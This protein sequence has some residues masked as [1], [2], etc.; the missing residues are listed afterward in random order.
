MCWCRPHC[1]SAQRE[2]TLLEYA[3][4]ICQQDKVVAAAGRG[5]VHV[6]SR[7]DREDGVDALVHGPAQRSAA[8]SSQDKVDD[9]GLKYK[10]FM[11]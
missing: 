6:A 7:Y 2:E 3:W 4:V 8:P 11:V 9:R 5:V 1:N 10:H